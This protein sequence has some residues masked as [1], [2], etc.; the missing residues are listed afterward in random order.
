MKIHN[1]SYFF[2]LMICFENELAIHSE[3]LV[4]QVQ[5]GLPAFGLYVK[6]R[7]FH[8]IIF[9]LCLETQSSSARKN[10]SEQKTSSLKQMKPQLRAA[11]S[12]LNTKMQLQE[13]EA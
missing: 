5:L 8:F 11:D 12:A 3:N 10:V 1:R 9:S 7:I 2:F 13:E 6:E 4:Q